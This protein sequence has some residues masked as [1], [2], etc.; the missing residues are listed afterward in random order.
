[1]AEKAFLK[2]LTFFRPGFSFC[3]KWGILFLA[4]NPSGNVRASRG[5]IILICGR[6]CV[7]VQEEGW[8]AICCINEKGRMRRVASDAFCVSNKFL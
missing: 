2:S 6:G 1:M 3:R 8:E 4:A 5:N 7:N